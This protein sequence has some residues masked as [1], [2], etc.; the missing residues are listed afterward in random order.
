MSNEEIVNF[1]DLEPGIQELIKE[2]AAVRKFSY[3]PYSKFKV[4][5]AVLCVDGTISAG[6]NVENASYPVGTCAERVAIVKAVS[7]GKK[8]FKALAVV[9]DK[10]KDSFV[11]PCG[12]CRQAI[13]EFGDIPV[14]LSDPEMK[15]AL[16][17]TASN[18]L[19]RAF[20]LG[21]HEILH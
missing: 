5:A 2:S 4:G 9:A 19:P 1:T 21:N 7:D 10:L 14:Y 18:L 15:N 6:C 11:T 8:Q 20:G 3:S 17:T 12:F 13:V 16:R